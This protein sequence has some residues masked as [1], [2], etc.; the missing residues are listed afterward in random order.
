MG[1]ASTIGSMAGGTSSNFMSIASAGRRSKQV[2][3]QYETQRKLALY[4]KA[5]AENQAIEARNQAK[6]IEQS[7][8]VTKN[9]A[10][11]KNVAMRM[12]QYVSQSMSG[13]DADSGTPLLVQQ[14]QLAETALQERGIT[15]QG[16]LQSREKEIQA[17]HYD[18]QAQMAQYQAD[19]ADATSKYKR[20]MIG[21]QKKLTIAKMFYD[22]ANL[23]SFGEVDDPNQFQQSKVDFSAFQP[24]EISSSS[25]GSIDNKGFHL[26]NSVAPQ[27]GSL[28]NAGGTGGVTNA[29][30]IN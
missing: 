28:F 11:R 27:H 7:A 4:N 19:V 20:D 26:T 30:S 16:Y 21:F 17:Q 9:Q 23:T 12:S 14:D 2:K 24:D 5:L 25:V 1:F 29:F 8:H 22:G 18:S 3:E 6:L 13:V 10:H 15:Y